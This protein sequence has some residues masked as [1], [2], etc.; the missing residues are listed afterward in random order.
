MKNITGKFLKKKDYSVAYW[1]TE[2]ENKPY[3]VFFNGIFHGR[4]AWRNQTKNRDLRKNFNFLFMD[5]QGEGDSS[6]GK[7]FHFMKVSED[8]K[9]ILKKENI[10]KIH[11]LAYS[12]GGMLA[13]A[14]VRSYPHLC[15]SLILMNTSYLMS[16]QAK[17]MVDHVYRGVKAN[18]PLEEVFSEVYP[19]FFSAPYLEKFEGIEHIITGE[20]AAYN[21]SRRDL[22]R[23]LKGLHE[24]PDL[25]NF[26]KELTLPVLFLTGEEDRIFPAEKQREAAACVADGEHRVFPG[27][28]HSFFVEDPSEVNHLIY[29]F[30]IRRSHG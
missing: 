6:C 4:K 7:D 15:E 25:Q 8:L 24:K 22:L 27:G 2:E 19:L 14:F 23:M 10:N 16:E 17:W 26:L 5:Y 30:L 12:L 29:N 18:T 11:I 3:L 9:E 20:Y 13:T 1:L 28:S 21:S